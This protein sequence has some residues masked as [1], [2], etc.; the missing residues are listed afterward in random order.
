LTPFNYAT[1]AVAGTNSLPLLRL[2]TNFFSAYLDTNV[3]IIPVLNA[4]SSVFPNLV[5][6]F[7][8]GV[9]YYTNVIIDVYQLD[10]VGW[11][12]GQKFVFEVLTDHATYTNG[13]PQ[14]KKYLGSFPVANSGSFNIALPGGT[15]WGDGRVTVTANYSKD[16]A[17]TALAYTTTSDFSMPISVRPLIKVAKSGGNLNITWDPA[18]ALYTVQTN[19]VVT[20]A[21]TWGNHTAG[22][23]AQ[24]VSVPIGTGTR[25]VRLKYTP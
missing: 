24:P 20:N 15:D 9:G 12:N 5:G 25:F 14:G 16:P 17:G 8:P 10:P 11:T 22:N 19:A 18:T 3:A 23:V 1:N 7:S 13:F 4:G 6:T 21:A 2:F